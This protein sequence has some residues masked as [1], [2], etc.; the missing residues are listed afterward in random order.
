[1]KLCILTEAQIDGASFFR[2]DG[3]WVFQ[4]GDSTSKST[5]VVFILSDDLYSSLYKWH[6]WSGRVA[7]MQFKITGGLISVFG[8]YAPYEGIRRADDGA[9]SEAQR[10]SH[11]DF[12]GDKIEEARRAGL[13]LVLGDMNTSFRWRRTGE[14]SHIGRHLFS[15]LDSTHITED[16]PDPIPPGHTE[17]LN[18][19][20]LSELCQRCGCFVANTFFN[21]PQWRKATYRA[22]G[23]ELPSA[24][25]LDYAVH[26]G[27]DL[28]LTSDLNLVADFYGRSNH[29]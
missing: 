22:W 21:K 14:E 25:F 27:L 17:A 26:K 18:R 8:V 5:G 16:A 4:S 28:V 3:F 7:L 29:R 13:V 9:S 23:A 19:D 15:P 24:A 2:F 20:L 10:I 6:P 11:W 12:L 1:M